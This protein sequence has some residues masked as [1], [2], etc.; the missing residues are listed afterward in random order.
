[1]KLLQIKEYRLTTA[2]IVYHYPDPSD[3]VADVC[4]AKHGLGARLP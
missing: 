1:M 4:L 3:A 2:E